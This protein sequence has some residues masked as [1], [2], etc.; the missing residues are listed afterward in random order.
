MIVSHDAELYGAQLLA[1]YLIK[2]YTEE[3]SYEVVTMLLRDGELTSEFKKY[4]RVIIFPAFKFNLL[5]VLVNWI[6]RVRF[7]WI[8]QNGYKSAIINTTVSARIL[9]FL[10]RQSIKSL[11]LI[12]ELPGLIKGYSLENATKIIS[13]YADHVVFPAEIVRDSFALLAPLD[14]TVTSIRPQGLYMKNPYKDSKS[15]VHC[16]LL[17]LLDLPSETKIV[18][19]AGQGDRRKGV[20][21]FCQVAAHVARVDP[22]VHFVWIG[23]DQLPLTYDCKAWLHSQGLTS[24]VSFLGIVRDPVAYA[25]Y[26]AAADLFLM[27]SREDPYPSVVLDAMTLGIPVIGFSSA[28][29]FCELLEEG[30]GRLVPYEDINCMASETIKLL[31]DDRESL[32]CG[33]IGQNII[34]TRFNF[35]DYGIDLLRKLDH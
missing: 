8:F 27:T 28:G 21:L 17:Q 2:Y 24:T 6:F 23:N 26:L 5:T 33:K 15:D 35:S 11:V 22:C 25:R 9:P 3:L 12:H 19:A 20:D 13:S 16:D 34:E 18:I 30:A 32:L 29:G 4:S 1:L 14:N 7:W 31:H 10:H